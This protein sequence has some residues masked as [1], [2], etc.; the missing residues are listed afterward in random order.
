MLN[1]MKRDFV[2]TNLMLVSMVV[3]VLF[4]FIVTVSYDDKMEEVRRVGKNCKNADISLHGYY[5]LRH[6]SL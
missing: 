1:K 2:L 5:N 4:G 6:N 3:A